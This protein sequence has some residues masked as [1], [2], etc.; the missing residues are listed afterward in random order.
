MTEGSFK[1]P[2]RVPV[3]LVN[4]NWEFF[5]GGPVPIKAGAVGELI[6]E[7]S[8]LTD[9]QFL[10]QI[11]RPSKY[12][13]LDE[14]AELRVALTI[15]P[16]PSLDNTLSKHL[17]KM[18]AMS[19]D[20]G[21]EFFHTPRS[22]DTQFVKITVAK[23]TNLQLKSSPEETGGVWLHLKGSQPK[24]IT[25]SSMKIPEG[26]T[27]ETVDS[28]NYVFTLLSQ[29]YEPWRKSHTGNIYD[30]VLYQEANKKWY[31]LSVLREAAMAKD[32]HQLIRERWAE[33]TKLLNLNFA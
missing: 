20:L 31:P 10:E 17:I 18:S 7:K 28:L 5:Y 29:Q 16:S 32:E 22:P 9:K 27:S 3:R 21:A 12:K 1:S 19:A 23:P 25:T 8:A 15:K 30:R 33:L 4:G 6:V 11:N 24:G 14:G 2:V 26:I 13:I